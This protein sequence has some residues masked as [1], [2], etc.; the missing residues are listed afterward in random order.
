MALQI[1]LERA[2]AQE[3]P[4]DLL[5]E[6]GHVGRQQAMQRE[7]RALG[8]GECHPLVQQGIGEQCRALYSNLG[9]TLSQ[10]GLPNP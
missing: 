7:R 6:G 3:T 8:F 1:G 5:I 9:H 2:Q 10:F 4:L